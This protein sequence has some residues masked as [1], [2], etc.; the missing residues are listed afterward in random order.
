MRGSFQNKLKTIS[1]CCGESTLNTFVSVHLETDS[2]PPVKWLAHNIQ[3][4]CQG[5]RPAES[6]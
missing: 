5:L 4:T 6:R 1:V 2:T 3:N